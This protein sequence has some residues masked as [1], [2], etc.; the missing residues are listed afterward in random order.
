MTRKTID[1][2][3]ESFVASCGVVPAEAHRLEDFDARRHAAT[4]IQRLIGTGIACHQV[5]GYALGNSW[6]TFCF[7][8]HTELE[9]DDETE[10]WRV[11]AYDSI[12]RGWRDTFVY[13]LDTGQWR[14]RVAASLTG[15]RSHFAKGSGRN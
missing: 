6:W 4:W 3:M 5:I 12:G 7:D 2:R 13:S 15:G 11:E 8:R 9:P 14:L 1:G 10:V